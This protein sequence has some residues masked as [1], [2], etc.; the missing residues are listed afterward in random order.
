MPSADVPVAIGM[1]VDDIAI[2]MVVVAD[3]AMEV[4]MAL[5]VRLLML[6]GDSGDA[7]IS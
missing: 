3:I 1:E 6:G 5:A 2:G 7:A 4:D